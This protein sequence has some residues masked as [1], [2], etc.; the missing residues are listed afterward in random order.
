LL[1]V[2]LLVVSSFVRLYFLNEIGREEPSHSIQLTSPPVSIW[3]IRATVSYKSKALVFFKKG[4]TLVQDDNNISFLESEFV[5][6]LIE[7]VRY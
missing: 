4:L 7:T 1:V 5:I 3:F 2:R 6:L